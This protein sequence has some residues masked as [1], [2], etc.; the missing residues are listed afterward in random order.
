MKNSYLKT[1]G[2]HIL[3]GIIVYLLRG[4]GNLFLFGIVIYFVIKIINASKK[5]KAI[6]VI[7]AC[8]YVLSIEVLLRMSGGVLF[9]EAIKYLV[10]MFVIMG[11][12]YQGFNKKGTSYLLYL[13]FLI[14]GVYVSLELID[15]GTNIRTAIAFNLSGP[16][17]L[18]VISLVLFRI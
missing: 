14:P 1:L 11:L 17:C 12:I 13:L 5:L 15:A 6:E 16:V 10:I 8:V 7:K 2:L 18:G 4:Y 3:L 9:Y